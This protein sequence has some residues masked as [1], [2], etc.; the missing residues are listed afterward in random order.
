MRPNTSRLSSFGLQSG[1][2][3]MPPSNSPERIWERIDIHGPNECWPWTGPRHTAGYGQAHYANTSWPAHR[4]VWVLVKG[5][6]PTGLLVCHSC[7]NKLCCNPN[8]LWLGTKSDN[9]RDMVSKGLFHPATGDSNGAR[10][11]P[12][13][14]A[15]WGNQNA[16]GNHGRKKRS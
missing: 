10:R 1:D 15:R 11:H 6:I 2:C 3:Q 13:R 5:D 4:L 12:E 7:D 16:V 9:A 14:F 8:H